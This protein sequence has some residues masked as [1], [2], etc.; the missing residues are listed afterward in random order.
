MTLHDGSFFRGERA[1][2]P[3]KMRGKVREILH[4]PHLGEKSTLRRARECLF[5]PNMS[6]EIKQTVK[7]C[8]ISRTYDINQQKE[9]M[10][11]IEQPERL[12]QKVAV[13]LFE[14]DKK[15]FQILVDYHSGFFKTK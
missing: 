3:A 12:F 8:D 15:M 4:T 14:W 2:V 9:T 6:A 5:W 1:I 11:P 13:D 7:E 10:M